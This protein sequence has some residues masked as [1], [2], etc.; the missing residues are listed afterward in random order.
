MPK[1]H[2]FVAGLATAFLAA[3]LAACG[4]GGGAIATVNCTQISKSDFDNKLE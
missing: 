1:A 4:G 2:R 3:S